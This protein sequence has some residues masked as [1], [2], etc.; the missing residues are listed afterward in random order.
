[1]SKFTYLSNMFSIDVLFFSKEDSGRENVGQSPV[2]PAK[3]NLNST[4]FFV[5]L[6]REERNIVKEIEKIQGAELSFE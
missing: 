6:P 3:S 4:I 2:R 1:M 5:N